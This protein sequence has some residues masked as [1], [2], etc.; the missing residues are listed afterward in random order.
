MLTH[1]VMM[2]LKADAEPNAAETIRERLLA[3]PALIPEI[4]HY[5]VGL[6]VMRSERSYDLVLI[7]RFD[8]REALARYSQ[9]PDHQAVLAYIRAQ[10][11]HVAVV[12]YEGA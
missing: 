7:S 5:E 9:Q 11:E 12:D 6:D 8:D 3:L 10:A 2:K 4:R 1:V